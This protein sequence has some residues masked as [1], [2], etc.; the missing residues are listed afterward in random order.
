M[1]NQS[2]QM[3]AAILSCEMA[4]SAAEVEAKALEARAHDIRCI[5]RAS[6]DAAVSAYT[7]YM[8]NNGIVEDYLSGNTCDYKISFTTP[9]ESVDVP[10]AN[11]VPDDFLRMKPE[12]DKKKIAEHLRSLPE[13]SRPNWAAMKLGESK[14]TWK[15]VKKGKA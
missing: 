13:S 5:A 7:D 9:R 12:P 14:L 8:H 10:D 1:D 3:F 4:Q 15:P 2:L 11:A 6:L